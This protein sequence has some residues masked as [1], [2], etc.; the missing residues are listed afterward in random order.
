VKIVEEQDVDVIRVEHPDE[1]VLVTVGQRREAVQVRATGVVAPDVNRSVPVH[2]LLGGRAVDIRVRLGDEVQKGQLLLMISSPDLAQ[3][4]SDYKKFRADEE[5]ARTQLER[6]RQ[7][8][9][10]GAIAHKDL[11]VSEDTHKKAQVDLET[12]ADRIRILGGDPQRPTTV[13]EVRAPVTGAIVEQNVTASSG[14]RSLENSPNL[15]T[16]ADLSRVWVL[17]DVYEND[18]SQVHMGDSAEVLLNAYPGRQFKGKVEN[19][20]RVLDP[21]TRSAKVRLELENPNGLLRPG[22]FAVATFSSQTGELR[23]IVP[24]SAILHLHDKDWVF[25]FVQGGSF[26]RREIQSGRTGPDG[27]VTVLSGISAGDKIV[28]NA[29]QFSTAVGRE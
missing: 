5:L 10:K 29:L 16:I 28:T 13:L 26:H 15:F 2:S 19:I 24:A 17:C 7:L 1:F 14:V 18:L 8:Y 21:A 3:A 6:A 23:P 25:Q 11:Q 27:F 12:G 9:E 4:F 20:S 22:M